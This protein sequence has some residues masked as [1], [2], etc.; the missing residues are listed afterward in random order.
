MSFERPPKISCCRKWQAK[1]DVWGPSISKAEAKYE[2]YL[3]TERWSWFGRKILIEVFSSCYLI[4][5][6]FINGQALW[7]ASHLTPYCGA[8]SSLSLSSYLVNI[9]HVQLHQSIHQRSSV[10]TVACS[11]NISCN[12]YWGVVEP[13]FF[14]FLTY[15]SF[16]EVKKLLANV[17]KHYFSEKKIPAISP[18]KPGFWKA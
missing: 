10:S 14:F 11:S 8:T 18:W 2:I 16:I 3:V 6:P 1:I 9:S 12:S 17:D 13:F 4:V 7:V 15:Y 5:L